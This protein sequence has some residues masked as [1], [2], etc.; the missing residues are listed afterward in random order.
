MSWYFTVLE[1]FLHLYP[2]DRLYN[3]TGFAQSSTA[4]APA[5]ALPRLSP[6]SDPGGGG[7]VVQELWRHA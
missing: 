3:P 6:L 5:T 2:L 7:T 4:E 1:C